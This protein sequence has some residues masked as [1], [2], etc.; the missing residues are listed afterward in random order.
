[1]IHE[2][3]QGIAI[4]ADKGAVAASRSWPA[5]LAEC[6]KLIDQVADRGAP[7]VMGGAFFNLLS[8]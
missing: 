4:S 8:R 2:K 6:A 5:R 3:D 7:L 1:L